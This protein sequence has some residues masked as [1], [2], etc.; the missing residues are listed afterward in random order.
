MYGSIDSTGVVQAR[1]ALAGWGGIT[2]KNFADKQSLRTYLHIV[3]ETTYGLLGVSSGYTTA[4]FG[5]YLEWIC[6]NL[7]NENRRMFMGVVN[8]DGGYSMVICYIYNT[9]ATQNG[10]PQYSSGIVVQLGGTAEM[11]KIIRKINQF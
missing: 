8:A 3:P 5:A 2:G 9:S 11:K 10:V 7:P 6:Q 4:F 1:G